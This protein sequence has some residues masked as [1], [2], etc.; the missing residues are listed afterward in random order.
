MKFINEIN[1]QIFFIFLVDF[2][3]QCAPRLR[4]QNISWAHKVPVVAPEARRT[5]IT[6][7]WESILALHQ[8]LKEQ[9]D[10]TQ[11]NNRARVRVVAYHPPRYLRLYFGWS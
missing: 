5:S 3:G 6:P 4:C 2:L 9:V 1:S 7:L 8:L 11:G 10:F